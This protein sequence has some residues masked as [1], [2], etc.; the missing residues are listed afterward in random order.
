MQGAHRISTVAVD[1]Q[2]PP[3]SKAE[4]S[5]ASDYIDTVA[6]LPWSYKNGKDPAIQTS[7]EVCNELLLATGLNVFLVKSPNGA[8]P[9]ATPGT[10]ASGRAEPPFEHLV[11]QGRA[12]LGQE[13]INRAN[14][15]FVLPT[16]EEMSAIGERL[17]TRYV[18]AGRAQW[19]S[20]N[21]WVGI[22]NRNKSI[23][24]VDLM[25]EDMDSK[26][27][28]LDAHNIPGDSTENKSL[29]SDVTSVIALNPL[30]LVL[31]GS[32]TPEQQ[33]A[34]TVAVAKAMEP[35]LKA[36]RIK[37]ALAQADESVEAAAPDAGPS[38]KLSTFIAPITDLHAHLEV[39]G[40][41]IRQVETI[42]ADLARL[43]ALHDVDLEYKEPERL[44]L[45]AASG[46]D[47]QETLTV[48]EDTRSLTVGDR[49][50][51]RPQELYGAPERRISLL[52]V[53]GVMTRGLF[54]TMRARF[55]RED[56]QSGNADVVYDLTYW[57]VEEGPYRR[58]WLEPDTHRVLRIEFHARDGKLRAVVLFQQPTD[59][60]PSINLPKLIT[61]KNAAGRSIASIT[62]SNARV[63]PASATE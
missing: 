23:C 62:V 49:K 33:R 50:P 14:S 11:N 18:L 3:E 30:P 20:R 54:E 24:T 40:P 8:I 17:G 59:V 37:M 42:D 46:R 47:E 52:E 57:G 27:L 16:L 55:V 60:A 4:N 28:V 38:A 58:V 9:P 15:P 31:P 13:E 10:S 48:D 34:V 2:A 22:S 43:Y 45:T 7:R 56:R 35:W 26:S 6:I 39:T 29:F 63:T 51:A 36:E 21:V 44:R 5:R 1:R 61:I 32:I 53:C 25:I 19:S 41:D 12:L